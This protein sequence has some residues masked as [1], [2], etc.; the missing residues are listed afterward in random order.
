MNTNWKMQYHEV[1]KNFIKEMNALQN[2]QD[3]KIKSILEQV[4]T[5][6]G[7]SGIQVWFYETPALE[8]TGEGDSIALYASANAQDEETRRQYRYQT[9][10]GNLVRYD[11][12]ALP[13]E[14]WDESREEETT[15]LIDTIFSYHGKIRTM[16]IA[17]QLKFWDTEF[18]LHNL[19]FFMKTLGER[20]A[21]NQLTGYIACMYNLKHFS[22]VNDLVGRDTGTEIM[23]RYAKGLEALFETDELVC[24]LGGD[25]FLTL[26]RTEKLEIVQNYL[27]GTLIPYGSAEEDSILISASAGFY[28]ISDTSEFHSPAEVMEGAYAS[29]GI[30]KKSEE[31]DMV[32]WNEEIRNRQFHKK[33]I[34]D[35]FP[36]ALEQEEFQVYYQPKISLKEPYTLVGA[37]AL[38]RW[39]H[40]GK[41]L[42]PDSFIPI[43]EQSA[44]IC[45]LDFYMLEHVCKDIKKWLEQ[46]K[47]VVTVSVNLSR[48]HLTDQNLLA[49]ILEI[50]DRHRIPHEYIEIELTETT[51][52]VD[53]KDLKRI[54][55]GL[56]EHGISISVDDFGMGYS[57]LNLIRDVSWNVLKLDKSFLPQTADSTDDSAKKNIMLKYVI[58]MAQEM[59][60]KCIVEGVETDAHIRLLKQ[61]HCY[62]A[63]GYYFDKPLPIELFEQRL[64]NQSQ[65]YPS[66][67]GSQ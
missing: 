15:L 6:L 20:I 58:E 19:H 37:E 48:K 17:E 57:S 1:F 2:E 49:H 16:R 61:N 9:G 41:M 31:T 54:A 33:K 28:V 59:G 32:F 55:S 62:L 29:G 7:I 30:A 44:N 21:K 60:L 40:T 51:T 13:D 36:T 18:E 25:N 11:V 66:P 67:A 65:A 39:V 8:T 3:P 46:G 45:K 23:I 5:L 34:E 56:H 4:C 50:I 14:N 10:A 52:D 42:Y 26:F 38:C 64:Q 43:L 12:Y 22:L 63:Q 47:P 53:F 24:H 27:M 35:L